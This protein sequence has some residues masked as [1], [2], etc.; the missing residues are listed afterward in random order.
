MNQKQVKNVPKGI[1]IEAT[2]GQ[3]VSVLFLIVI[4][5][6]LPVGGYEYLSAR[7][8]TSDAGAYTSQ[9]LEENEIQE[10]GAAQQGSVAG[11]STVNA[12]STT[13]GV[14]E[15]MG[16]ITKSTTLVLGGGVLLVAISFGLGGSLLYDFWKR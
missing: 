4:M 11:I 1:K 13:E 5:F 15:T 12:Q 8:K 16:F 6:V 14:S 3:W 7:Y 10:E 9:S 2:F